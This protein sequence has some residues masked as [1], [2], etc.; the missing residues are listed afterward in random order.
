MSLLAQGAFSLG[1]LGLLGGGL[2]GGS[3]PDK[4]GAFN[5][6]QFR[7]YSTERVS[8]LGDDL[9]RFSDPEIGKDFRFFQ[10]ELDNFH[11]ED[12]ET[13][14]WQMHDTSDAHIDP[15]IWNLYHEQ[16][17]MYQGGGTD[18]DYNLGSFGPGLDPDKKTLPWQHFAARSG[19]NYNPVTPES[20]AHDESMAAWQADQRQQNQER[21]A[22]NTGPAGGFNF[23]DAARGG[24]A[25]RGQSYWD[26]TGTQPPP[27][28]PTDTTGTG[29]LSREHKPYMG[30]G[31][32]AGATIESGGRQYVMPS[33]GGVWQPLDESQPSQSIVPAPVPSAPAPAPVPPP[34]IPYSIGGFTPPR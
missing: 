23:M 26:V 17:K 24:Q 13:G 18:A 21:M 32:D 11:I 31:A 6:S 30:P 27:T 28:R 19:P 2:F 4:Q 14:Q 12:P 5:Q 16:Q 22:Q 8:Y 33:Q 34:T 15:I 7:D 3:R 1:R 25:N 10:D 20:V 9:W 29:V